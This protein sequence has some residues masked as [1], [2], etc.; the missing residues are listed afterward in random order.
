M[1][2]SFNN[3]VANIVGTPGAA[4]G[5]FAD[6][7]NAADVAEGTLYFATDTVEIYQVVAAAWVN[8]SGGG[9]VP[10]AAN[11]ISYDGLNYVLGGVGSPLIYDTTINADNHSFT[12]DEIKVLNF[13]SFNLTKFTLF[14]DIIKTQ[15]GVN[16]IGL[17][18]DFENDIFWL[19]DYAF[20]NNGT[21]LKIDNQNQRIFLNAYT[22]FGYYSDNV[23]KELIIGDYLQNNNGT[24]IE[25]NDNTQKINFYSNASKY[26]F[27]TMPAYTGNAAALAAG[28]VVGDLYRHSGAGESQDQLRIVH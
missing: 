6:R 8:Y 16:D 9:G 17:N 1:S 11:G 26:N 28:L 5:V 21:V 24:R 4:S 15:Y 23:S 10:G 22:G 12:L 13:S 14:D 27:A 25:I 3:S 7:P 20:N 18:L 19:G 2:I